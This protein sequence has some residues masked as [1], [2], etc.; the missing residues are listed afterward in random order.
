MYVVLLAGYRRIHGRLWASSA[1]CQ[2]AK[3]DDPISI[4]LDESSLVCKTF[5]I[6]RASFA[7]VVTLAISRWRR[8]SSG[9]TVGPGLDLCWSL[10]SITC[11]NSKLADSR[12]KSCH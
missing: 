9:V 7:A 12:Y 1:A 4:A 10:P 6:L 3:V 8:S 11:A 5:D 2:G